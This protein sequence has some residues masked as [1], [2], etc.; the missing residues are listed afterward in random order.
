MV[1]LAVLDPLQRQPRTRSTFGC[2]EVLYGMETERSEICNS[3]DVFLPPLYLPFAGM[4]D[5]TARAQGVSGIANDSHTTKRML[6]NAA[7][8]GADGVIDVKYSSAAIMQGVQS[9]YETDVLRSLVGLT[10]PYL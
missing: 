5:H 6:D 4:A 9:N 8:M 2:R 10:S 3:A 1:D 7:A